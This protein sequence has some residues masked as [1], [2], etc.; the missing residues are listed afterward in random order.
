MIRG[1]GVQ[2][3]SFRQRTMYHA[4]L[5]GG[6]A[7]I[8]SALIVIGNKQTQADIALRRAEDMKNS[9]AQVIHPDLHTNNLLDDVIVLTIDSET[10][11]FYIARSNEDVVAVAF[12]IISQGYAGPIDVL[13]GIN[14]NGELLGVRIL[15]HNETP[16]LGDKIES[17]KN[18]ISKNTG[19]LLLT[20]LFKVFIWLFSFIVSKP[21]IQE[22]K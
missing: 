6:M 3:P 22:S 13:V 9:L 11:N 1:K 14:S 18:L 8:T 16:G 2:N 17:E 7:M 12:D 10:K 5:L 20:K 21:I 4:M 15:S 19:I